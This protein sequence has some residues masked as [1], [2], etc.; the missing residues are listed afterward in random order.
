M[1]HFCKYFDGCLKFFWDHFVGSQ[2][3]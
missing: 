2:L 3:D 1:E